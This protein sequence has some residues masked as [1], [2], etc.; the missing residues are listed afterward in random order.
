MI[1][2]CKQLCFLFL[3]GVLLVPLFAPVPAN[4]DG[5]RAKIDTLVRD[6]RAGD[7]TSIAFPE[8][9]FLVSIINRGIIVEDETIEEDLRR[10]K[11][12]YL[13]GAQAG[14]LQDHYEDVL[15]SLAK[16]TE[17]NAQINGLVLTGALTDFEKAVLIDYVQYINQCVPELDTQC[18]VRIATLMCHLTQAGCAADEELEAHTDLNTAYEPLNLDKLNFYLALQHLSAGNQAGFKRVY[19]RLEDVNLQG[20]LRVL[21]EFYFRHKTDPKLLKIDRPDIV[22]RRIIREFSAKGCAAFDFLDTETEFRD[23]DAKNLFGFI[24]I[25]PTQKNRLLAQIVRTSIL[26]NCPVKN[27]ISLIKDQLVK[28]DLLFALLEFADKTGQATEMINTLRSV[29]V[30]NPY[31][32]YRFHWE[33]KMHE[34]DVYEVFGGQKLTSLRRLNRAIKREVKSYDGLHSYFYSYM[35]IKM[36]HKILQANLVPHQVSM[37]AIHRA[38]EVYV[39]RER[40]L[41]KKIRHFAYLGEIYKDMGLFPEYRQS[42][43]HILHDIVSPDL[44]RSLKKEV[45][46]EFSQYMLEQGEYQVAE[47]QILRFISAPLWPASFKEEDKYLADKFALTM[48]QKMIKR[49]ENKKAV[50]MLGY[51]FDK[52]NAFPALLGADVMPVSKII[53]N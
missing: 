36:L 32:K 6:W 25:T 33:A 17:Y 3:L 28:E 26:Y 43:R 37:D 49:G 7:D 20:S 40:D 48:A 21:E 53:L 30:V 12:D 10:L 46:I 27:K 13:R 9:H 23:A 47:V 1:R 29:K 50:R 14:N 45:L 51:M 4:A 34:I 8:T 42:Q 19:G 18:R 35:E 16:Y 41:F 38:Y 52:A 22:R 44:H 11:A 15:Q 24:Y 5:L 31:L 2:F 39:S